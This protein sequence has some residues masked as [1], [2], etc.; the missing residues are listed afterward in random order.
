MKKSNKDPDDDV[1]ESLL[2]GS[3]ENRDSNEFASSSKFLK[4]PTS[5]SS[6]HPK[7][8]PISKKDIKHD[9][10]KQIDLILDKIDEKIWTLRISKYDINVFGCSDKKDFEEEVLKPIIQKISRKRN[11][12]YDSICNVVSSRINWEGCY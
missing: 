7:T 4:I 1:L 12:D 11:F 8:F 9:Y 6:Y 3:T 10:R 2:R 5:I